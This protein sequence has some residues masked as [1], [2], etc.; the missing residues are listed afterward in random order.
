MTRGVSSSVSEAKGRLGGLSA[1]WGGCPGTTE[2][3]W[4][5]KYWMCFNAELL[6]V[7]FP[8]LSSV[9]SSP[10]EPQ[11]MQAGEKVWRRGWVTDQTAVERGNFKLSLRKQMQTKSFCAKASLCKHRRGK[12]LQ[13]SGVNAQT[14]LSPAGS[15]WEEL[16]LVSGDHNGNRNPSPHGW[17]EIGS[18]ENWHRTFNGFFS[19][20]FLFVCHGPINKGKLKVWQLKIHP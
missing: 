17:C 14:A 10:Q 15:N 16:I 6:N 12:P 2:N 8:S 18:S 20:T 9:K 19:Q 5:F 3:V 4:V 11:A 1:G 7:F 13:F